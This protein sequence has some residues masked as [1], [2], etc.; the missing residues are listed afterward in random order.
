MKIIFRNTNSI[1]DQKKIYLENLYLAI[2]SLVSRCRQ[3]EQ[4]IQFLKK[5]PL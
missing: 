3:D 1:F 4:Q 5:A 2:I